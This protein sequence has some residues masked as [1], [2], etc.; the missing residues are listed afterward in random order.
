MSLAARVRQAL[1]SPRGRWRLRRRAG[2]VLAHAA[3]SLL[4][5]LLSPLVALLVVRLAGVALWGEFVRVLV[6]VQ[7]A[8]HV[9]G[10]GNKDY[11]LREF[12]ARPAGLAAAWQGGLLARL[13]LWA[14]GCGA[15][16]LLGLDGA[17]LF[18][19]CLLAL[20]LVIAQSFEVFVIFKRA[21]G[22]ALLVEA[23][24]VAL[25]AAAVLAWGPGLGVEQ[26]LLLFAAASGLKAG[27]LWA[28]FRGEAGPA[29]AGRFEWRWLGAAFP[30]FALGF[31]GLLQ[32]RV[33][34]Y[35]V[36]A[37]LPP[38]DIGRYQVFMNFI[39]YLQAVAAFVLVPFLKGLYRL[40]YGRLL[41]LSGQIAAL[42]VLVTSAGIPALAFGLHHVFDL[43]YAPGFFLAGALCVLPLYVY[44]PTIYAFFKAGRPWVVV[45]LNLAGAALSGALLVWWLPAHGTLGAVWASA[46]AQ[47]TL[48]G[49]YLVLGRRLAA[50]NVIP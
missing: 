26:L 16:A 2:A 24:G 4:V 27:L 23:A 34:L 49:A 28:R 22:L 40:D 14:A 25:L 42:G 9:A 17:R 36:S 7:L 5:P 38:A 20:A 6:L 31:S 48:A 10:W 11:L 39:I 43:S 44:A 15:L 1:D 30:F 13:P 46:A 35:A 12:S 47:V 21:F 50:R 32:S 29:G 3:N 41:G 33:D 19:A 37:Y 45:A 18:A 8:A